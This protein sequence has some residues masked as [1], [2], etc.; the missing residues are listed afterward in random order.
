MVHIHNLQV[1]ITTTSV[2]IY[3][4][5]LLWEYYYSVR[6]IESI[7]N[8]EHMSSTLTSSLITLL[9]KLYSQWTLV[10]TSHSL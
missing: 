10:I 3:Y 1:L 4:G 5:W 7:D 8:T 6:V 2:C 9:T